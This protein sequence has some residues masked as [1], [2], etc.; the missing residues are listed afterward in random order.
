[1]PS[2]AARGPTATATS[3]DA[4]A[5]PAG[6]RR[7]GRRETRS[8]R[9]HDRATAGVELRRPLEGPRRQP[10]TAR[11]EPAPEARRDPPVRLV[12]AAGS[13][14]RRARPLGRD[15]VVRRGHRPAPGGMARARTPRPQPHRP[16]RARPPH[17]RGRPG[18]PL[19]KDRPCPTPR[20]P[21][22][23]PPRRAYATMSPPASRCSRSH[24]G[25]ARR[26]R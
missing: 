15:P 18:S 1:M 3:A 13:A 2:P 20:P 21:P 9:R 17:I 10:G 24:A 22:R 6:S 11:P 14:R 16:C 25:W 26:S 4:D 23:P 7:T 12:G 19:R 8:T 5:K